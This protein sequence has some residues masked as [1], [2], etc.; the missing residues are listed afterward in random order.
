MRTLAGRADTVYS[1]YA[2]GTSY[3]LTATP[4]LAHL[5]TTDPAITITKPGRYLIFA[6]A[7]VDYTGATFAAVRTVSMKL[8]RTNNTAA[9]ITGGASAALTNIITLLTYSLGDIVIPPV[10]YTTTN[11][12]DVIQLF[13]SVSVLPTA[14]TIDVSEAEIVAMPL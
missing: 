11:S 13:G 1:G 3:V 10:V 8:R 6:R 9:D 7:R 2:S 4:A 12:D 5:G 14:G